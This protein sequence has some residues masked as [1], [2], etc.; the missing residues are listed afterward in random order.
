MGRKTG[1]PFEARLATAGRH[2]KVL[3]APSTCP[4]FRSLTGCT[5]HPRD[6]DP[7]VAPLIPTDMQ[8]L[9]AQCG[10]THGNIAQLSNSHGIGSIQTAEACLQVGDV[11][12]VAAAD[13][14]GLV[15]D[16]VV[17]VEA[18]QA[19]GMFNP[20]TNE[21]ARPAPFLKLLFVLRRPPAFMRTCRHQCSHLPPQQLHDRDHIAA[22][23]ICN[24]GR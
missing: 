24:G 8:Y 18:V 12:W 10:A 16:T 2:V 7:A 6:P 20:Y 9:S 17:A 5:S 19:E 14:H 21:G 23:G 3:S 4:G 22:A 1:G 15:Q 11:L 13:G